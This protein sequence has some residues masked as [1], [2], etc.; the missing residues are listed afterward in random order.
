MTEA[1]PPHSERSRQYRRDTWTYG[2][3]AAAEIGTGIFLGEVMNVKNPLVAL[4]LILGIANLAACEIYS[5]KYRNFKTRT[6]R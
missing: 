2:T 1:R 4:P 6:R 5:K 3:V